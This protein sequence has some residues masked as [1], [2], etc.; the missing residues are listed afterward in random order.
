MQ[1]NQVVFFAMMVPAI[2]TPKGTLH[3][4]QWVHAVGVIDKNKTAS[5]Y[6]DGQ[7]VQQVAMPGD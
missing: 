7:L 4:G 2:K 6:L 3:K 5:L 1:N